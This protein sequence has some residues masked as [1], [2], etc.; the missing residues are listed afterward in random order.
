M[1]ITSPSVAFVGFAFLV[2]LNA[3]AADRVCVSDPHLPI[4]DNPR[5]PGPDFP[6][7]LETQPT[8]NG[9]VTVASIGHLIR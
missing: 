9:T 8:A 2:W 3:A 4:C 7:I 5:A 6:H 1:P